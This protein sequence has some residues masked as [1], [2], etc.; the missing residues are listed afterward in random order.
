MRC[1]HIFIL[2]SVFLV[3]QTPA[4]FGAR[5][6]DASNGLTPGTA[7]ARTVA[8]D[9]DGSTLYVMSDGNAVFKSSNG[10]SSWK[11]LGGIAGA[12]VLALDTASPANLYAGTLRGIRKSSDGGET[13]TSAGLAG[14][15]VRVIAVDPVTPSTLYAGAG[16]LIY[17]STDSA[18]TWT[19]LTLQGVPASSYEFAAIL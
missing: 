3:I 16:N 6:T 18:A 19:A 17:K 4:S 10:G 9:R 11:A 13:W 12:L 5:W 1:R 14:K 8:V 15:A 7:A 2:A